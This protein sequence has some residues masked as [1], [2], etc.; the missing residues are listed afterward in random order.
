MS[1]LA[2]RNP[3]LTKDQYCMKLIEVEKEL[4]EDPGTQMGACIVDKN[5]ILIS[6]GHNRSPKGF[7]DMPWNKESDN[8]LYNKY[9]YAVHAERDAIANACRQGKSVEGATI[10][11]SNFPCNECAI[12][13]VNFGISEV[14]YVTDNYANA[15]F[16]KAAKLILEKAGVVTRQYIPE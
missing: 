15:D 7:D 13:I 16:T 9:L 1:I 5:G 14:V 4:S 2:K 11:I 6:L 8:P 10:Y 12:E 3:T